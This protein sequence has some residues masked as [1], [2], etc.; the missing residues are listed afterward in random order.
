MIPRSTDCDVYIFRS[1]ANGNSEHHC[2][3]LVCS[4]PDSTGRLEETVMAPDPTEELQRLQRERDLYRALLRLGEEPNLDRFLEEALSLLVSV[5]SAAQGWIEIRDDLD[6]DDATRAWSLGHAVTPIEIKNIRDHVSTGII[7]EALATGSTV[8]TSSALLDE[9]FGNRDSV[10]A[11][12]IEAVLCATV[13]ADSARGVVYLQGRIAPGSFSDEDRRCAELVA[14][15]LAPLADRALALRRADAATDPTHDLRKRYRLDGFIGRSPAIAEAIRQGMLAAPLDVN[16]LITGASGTGKTQLARVIHGNSSRVG[17]PFVELNCA[18]LPSQL[19]ESELFGWL[20]GAFTG[21]DRDTPGKVAAAEG[22][23]LFLDEIGELPL[24]A[25]AKLLQL[26]QSRQYY[27]LGAGKPTTAD[28]RLVAATNADLDVAVRER[29]FRED[30]FFRLSVLPIDMP[31]LARRPQDIPPLVEHLVSTVAKRHRLPRLEVGRS[32]LAAISAAEWPGNV[33]QL[34]HALEAAAIR[35]AGEKADMIQTCH[36]F[37]EALADDSEGK[38]KT[39]H[40]ATRDFQRDLV[41]RALL[42]NNW[43]IV[44]TGTQLGLSRAHM[45]NLIRAFALERAVASR[46]SI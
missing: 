46:K 27:P 43:N 7:A 3:E 23:T 25:Q 44:A 30:L 37:P 29:R 13:G 2:V 22:G 38:A 10:R 5:T 32:A 15:H 26:L 12:G 8:L 16:V 18:A 19:L 21:A 20:K 24:E 40:Q 31:S 17:G 11:R 34:E 28:I 42:E 6:P 9:R 33:R 1:G 41:E 35:A 4:P 45:Y 39:F 14:H 36:V